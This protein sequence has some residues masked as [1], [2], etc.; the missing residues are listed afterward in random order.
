MDTTFAAE[1]VSCY[2]HLDVASTVECARCDRHLC[3]VCAFESAAGKLCVDC[4]T[5]GAGHSGERKTIGYSVAALVCASLGVVTLGIPFFG[6]QDVV[7]LGLGFLGVAAFLCFGGGLAFAVSGRD[8][9]RRTGSPLALI[10][11]IANGTLLALYVVL[12]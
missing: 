9:G 10:G 1:P 3:D 7:G 4:M 11:M 2:A 8:H 12:C 6:L 5:E